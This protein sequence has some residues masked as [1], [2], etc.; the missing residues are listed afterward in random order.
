M[1]IT[2]QEAKL[3]WCPF[4][5]MGY[6]FDGGGSFAYP[7]NR[8]DNDLEGL[9]CKG[10]DC[11]AWRYVQESDEEITKRVQ[12]IL[13]AKPDLSAQEAYDSLPKRGFCGLAG[14]PQ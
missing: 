11:M 12:E 2:E 13:D 6:A 10:P 5:R 3:K 14:V 8:Y 4:V 1:I 9:G 7:F